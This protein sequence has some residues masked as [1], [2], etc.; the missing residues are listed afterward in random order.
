MD[1][2]ELFERCCGETERVV[3][4]VRPNALAQPTPCA[5]WDVRALLNHV[6]GTLVVFADALENRTPAAP[7]DPLA[8]GAPDLVGRRPLA[9]YQEAA[10]RA[11][12]ASRREGALDTTY[13]SAFGDMP[14][15]ALFGFTTMDVLVH[16][17]DIARAT[18]QQVAL[19]PELAEAVLGFARQAIMPAMR[20]T[21]I[22]PEI[23]VAAD[24]PVGDRLLAFVGRRP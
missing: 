17:W 24:A 10:E 4:G 6:V 9:A 22:G 8:H 19:D 13:P 23:D 3:A 21:S 20:G 18:D 14:G 16:G 15:G 12:K 7:P 5:Q 11:L 2:V 1:P